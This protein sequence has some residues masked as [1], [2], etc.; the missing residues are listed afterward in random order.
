MKILKN[1]H[2]SQCKRWFTVHSHKIN[3]YLFSFCLI[4]FLTTITACSYAQKDKGRLSDKIDPKTKYPHEWYITATGSGDT[5]ESAEKKAINGIAQVVKVDIKSQQQLMENFIEKGI[6]DNMRLQ[7]KSSFSN[8]IELTTEQSLKNI[9]IDKTWISDE[10][11]LYYAFAYM[12]RSETSDILIK[13]LEAMDSEISTFF[14][15]MEGSKTKL[16]AFSYISKAMRLVMLRE[17]LSEQLNSISLGSRTYTPAIAS[18]ELLSKRHELAKSISVKLD[19][20]YDKWD[21]F[22]NSVSEVIGA[23]GLRIVETDPDIIVSGKLKMEHL[24]RKGFF[25]RW[26]VELHFTETVSNSEF[27]TY[28][29]DSREGHKSYSEAERRAAKRMSIEVRKNLHRKFSEYLESILE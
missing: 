21:E 18:A 12:D 11:G 14:K 6:G 8:Q 4:I 16:T 29:D 1:I 22:A 26:F 2:K 5:K 25:V 27:L 20:E 13:D 28:S 9:S 19:L 24:E 7:A 3:N 15:E 17:I 10:D 23:F